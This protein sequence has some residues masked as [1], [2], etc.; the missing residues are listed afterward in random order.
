MRI[1]RIADLEA[2][3]AE[4]KM[5]V[6]RLSA[7]YAKEKEITDNWKKFLAE[8]G[9]ELAQKDA[10]IERLTSDYTDSAGATNHWFEK[11][12]EAEDEIER[13]RKESAS[14]L[15]EIE[16]W[17]KAA[18][19]GQ[20]EIE[21]L[22]ELLAALHL[23][24]GKNKSELER[25]RAEVQLHRN[26]RLLIAEDLDNVA[27]DRDTLHAKVAEQKREIERLKKAHHNTVREAQMQS[28]EVVC[29]E[30]M[31][32]EVMRHMDLPRKPGFETSQILEAWGALRSQLEKAI[33]FCESLDDSITGPDEAELA[34]T[35][36]A[37]LRGES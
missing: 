25:L 21:R 9:T 22:G 6:E 11:Y 8:K 7:L 31:I 26:A 3:V 17:R 13:T 16:D 35:I 30:S 4:Q 12:N 14:R 1:G 24:N 15:G 36:I 33:L 10:E 29:Y 23:E 32:V 19:V 20:A 18:D 28:G 27:T 5:E 2:K 37:K 34:L